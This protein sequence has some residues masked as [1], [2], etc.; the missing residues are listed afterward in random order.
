VSVLFGAYYLQVQLNAFDGQIV[1]ALMAYNAGPGRVRQW[2]ADFP[3]VDLLVEMAPISEPA[4]YVRLIY[5]N[6]YRYRQ[7]YRSSS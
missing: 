4:R 2:L 6:Y 3:D 5:A 1:P 7:L